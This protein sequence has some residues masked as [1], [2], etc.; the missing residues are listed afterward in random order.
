MDLILKV[1]SL[2]V[3]PAA[4][5]VKALAGSNTVAY[6]IADYLIQILVGVGVYSSTSAI[7]TKVNPGGASQNERNV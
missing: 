5:A 1:L 7:Q 4:I 6:H 2:V 3:A